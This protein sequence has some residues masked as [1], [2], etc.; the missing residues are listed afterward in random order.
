MN[1]LRSRRTETKVWGTVRDKHPYTDVIDVRQM[2]NTLHEIINV[3]FFASECKHKI[4][5][6]QFTSENIKLYNKYA[7]KVQSFAQAHTL[8]HSS[9]QSS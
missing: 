3:F 1:G 6:I 8:T 4:I 9:Q 5:F 7:Y 2:P